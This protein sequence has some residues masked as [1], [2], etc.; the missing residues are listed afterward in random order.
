MEGGQALQENPNIE[1]DRTDLI[2]IHVS[3]ERLGCRK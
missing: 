2:G 1:E 3:L